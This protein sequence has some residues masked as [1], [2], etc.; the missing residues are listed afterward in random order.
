MD[1]EQLIISKKYFELTPSEL[2]IVSE[3]VSNESE[4]ED[5]KS[6][7]VATQNTF[8]SQKIK[9]TPELDKKIMAHLHAAPTQN[10]VWYK[11]L[12][13]FLFPR[14]RRVYQYPAFQLALATVLIFGV[15]NLLNFDSLK[16]ESLAYED[17][18]KSE[19]HV[20]QEEP[21]LELEEMEEE[22]TAL[23]DEVLVLDSSAIVT[24]NEEF[25]YEPTSA[26]G[27][28]E[29]MVEESADEEI[30]YLEQNFYESDGD[31]SLEVESA[32]TI[33]SPAVDL[34]ATSEKVDRNDT[35]ID[36]VKAEDEYIANAT[37]GGKVELQKEVER[38]KKDKILRSNNN[39]PS[40][41]VI[42]LDN[43][44]EAKE[45]VQINQKVTI[46]STPELMELF[47][48]EK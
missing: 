39:Q 46:R 31:K 19:E 43:S 12:M 22:F 13:L 21:N 17:V 30:G 1:A 7:L 29:I 11:S 25:N 18:S 38:K 16:G 20:K 42:T 14:D 8:E 32:T 26:N 10:K 6:F 27:S 23:K 47:Y 15:F 44:S 3:L 45:S 48:E 2:E 35:E 33:T 34:K 36:D 24:K 28:V 41:P 40:A 4:F 37:T 5:M 9:A